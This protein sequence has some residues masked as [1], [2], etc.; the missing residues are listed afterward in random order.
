M[1]MKGKGY[2]YYQFNKT[3]NQTMLKLTILYLE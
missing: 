1:I 3:K 2:K